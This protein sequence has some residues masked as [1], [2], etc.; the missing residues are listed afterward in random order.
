MTHHGTYDLATG[1]HDTRGGFDRPLRT[2]LVCTSRRCGS[3]LLG[4]ALYRAG[5][6]GCPLEYL[7]SGFRPTFARRWHAA[8]LA[9]YVAALY[10]H[11]IDATGTLGVK[12]FWPDL[13]LTCAERWP[14]SAADDARGP[15]GSP[16]SGPRALDRV[17]A[18]IDE[19]FPNPTFVHLW[20]TDPVRQAVSDCRAARTLRW[21]LF[22]PGQPDITPTIDV[23]DITAAIARFAWQRRQ[24]SNWFEATG[25]EPLTLTYERLIADYA[26]VTR[27][28][29]IRLG[30]V[31]PDA[32]A[33]PPRL[34]RQSD[35][36]SERLAAH[37]LTTVAGRRA[38]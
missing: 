10:R 26:T 38:H 17:T 1:A 30:G 4:E 23:S 16:V 34:R 37:Y 7:H 24:W 8:D 21:R 25:R 32:A 6:L 20:R 35:T 31:D 28:V 29:A 5:G 12:L 9:D 22:A 2:V 27:R 19:L 13:L 14:D 3:T 36:D 18:L 11:R 15:A 33:A